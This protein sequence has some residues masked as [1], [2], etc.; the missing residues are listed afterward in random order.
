MTAP[1]QPPLDFMVIGAIKA[2]TTWLQ[3]Q[4]QHHPRA[5]MPDIEPHF[6]SRDHDKGWAWYRGLFPDRKAE[7]TLWGEKTA[8]YFAN[9]EAAARI[10]AAYP[11]IRLV[12]QFRNP[13]ERAYSDYK[14]LFRRGHVGRDVA[15][16]LDAR[17][18]E[19][20]R[21]LDNGRY[22]HHL[23]RW[24]E[25]FDR[26]QMLAFLFEDV[27]RDPQGTL[28][29]TC[30]HLGLPPHYDD[31]LAARSQ[32]DSSERFLPLPVRR[33]LAPLKPLAK[34]LRGHALFEKTRSIL[35]REIDYP[36]L[37][38]DLRARLQ[39]FYHDDIRA[40]ERLIGRD[41]SH[42]LQPAAQQRGL[43]TCAV[44]A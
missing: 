23:A 34:P 6:F 7:G 40:L 18:A 2:A 31:T 11:D 26:G 38:D 19:M 39:D 28:A 16:Y 32:N 42:W 37:D 21:F 33:A 43:T 29:R 44:S 30:R 3:V 25:H 36:A 24:L 41:L 4:M 14:M 27:K 8:D 5:F 12:V 10:G 22:A 17:S 20:P 13:V 9:P 15:A 1:L 35:A